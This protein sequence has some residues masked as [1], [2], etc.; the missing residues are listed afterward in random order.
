MAED[1]RPWDRLTGR[2]RA[3]IVREWKLFGAQ[4]PARAVPG[5]ASLANAIAD[6]RKSLALAK[7][8]ERYVDAIALSAFKLGLTEAG[9]IGEGPL[10]IGLILDDYTL[11]DTHPS[12]LLDKIAGR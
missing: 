7:A 2:E 4:M 10:P 1:A 5:L 12:S 6:A 3:A 8:R 9:P 11:W